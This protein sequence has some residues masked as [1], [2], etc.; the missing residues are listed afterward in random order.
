MSEPARR[1]KDIFRF[2]RFAISN[3][4]SAQKVG[5]NGVIIGALASAPSPGEIWDVGAGTGLIALM[6]AQRYPSAHI[7]AIEIDSVAAL[8]CKENAGAS[9]WHDR[10]EVV[11]GDVTSV[12]IRLKDPD[13]IVSNPPFFATT[14]GRSPDARRAIA[15]QDGSLSPVSL[16]GIAVERLAPGGRL[17]FIAPYD[18]NDEITLAAELARMNPVEVVDIAS[19][20]DKRPQRRVWT[21]MRRAE[22]KGVAVAASRL[23]IRTSS[24]DGIIIFTEPYID[25]TKDFYLDF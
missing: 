19:H 15:R 23:D 12:S 7:S 18:R 10:V 20:S 5:T 6:L 2:K 1:S 13:M 9:P 4:R 21:M 16:I 22:S 17:V 3:T 14:G 11:E 24:P 8:E 25:L